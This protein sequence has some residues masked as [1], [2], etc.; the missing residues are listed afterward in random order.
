MIIAVPEREGRIDEHFGH[1]D[2]YRLFSVDE[3]KKAVTREE[4]LPS[5]AGCGC[6]S[7]IGPVLGARGVSYML[8]GSIGQGA[9]NVL[10]TNGIKVVAGCSGDTKAVVMS[11]L[12][13]TLR[14]DGTPCDHHD[15][16]CGHS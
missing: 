10:G 9:I 11:W 7:N 1:C 16:G 6:K 5:P 14:A 8:A 2:H 4:L 13:G 3:K 12:D 15:E